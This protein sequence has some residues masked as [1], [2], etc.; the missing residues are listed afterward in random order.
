MLFRGRQKLVQLTL[1]ESEGLTGTVPAD[2]TWAWKESLGQAIAR[3]K[4]CVVSVLL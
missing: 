3:I 4:A 2:V 1:M